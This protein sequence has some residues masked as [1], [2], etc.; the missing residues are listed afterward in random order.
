MSKSTRYS[1]LSE[2]GK[3]RGD[4]E[5][6]VKNPQPVDKMDSHEDPRASQEA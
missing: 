6:D 5:V 4:G 1:F 3:G 2:S